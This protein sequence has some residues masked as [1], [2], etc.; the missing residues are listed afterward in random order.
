AIERAGA[1]DGEAIKTALMETKDFEGVTGNLSFN[2]I[3]DAN[4]DMAVI[5]TV[6]DGKFVFV[7]S[8]TVEK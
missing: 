4:K 6:K 7:Q 8:V 5:K 3:G 2:E 1:T